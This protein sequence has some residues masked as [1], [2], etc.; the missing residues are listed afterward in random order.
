MDLEIIADCA[1]RN[2][3]V[4][5]NYEKINGEVKTYFLEP[6]STREGK[7]LFGF[8]RVE[9]KIKKFLVDNI[10][11]AEETEETFQPQWEIEL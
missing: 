2:K 10:I 4:R 6:Y 11:S 1:R 3:V 5:V 9:G 7:Y 8:D